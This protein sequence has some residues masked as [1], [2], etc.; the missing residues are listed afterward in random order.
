MS[1]P[2]TAS[3]ADAAAALGRAARATLDSSEDGPLDAAAA[4]EI[5]G[6]AVKLYAASAGGAPEFPP[7]AS[8][9]ATDVAVTAS[10]MLA[11][12]EIEVFELGMWQAWT[13]R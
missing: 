11:A 7:A 12:V 8:V 5:L 10:A 9:T 1:S 2:E 13:P 6:W 3:L 4:A